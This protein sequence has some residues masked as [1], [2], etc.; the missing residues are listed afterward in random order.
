MVVERIIVI[1]SFYYFMLGLKSESID[2]LQESV[3][4]KSIPWITYP[5]QSEIQRMLK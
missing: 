5:I 3:V 1:F 4:D 2:T